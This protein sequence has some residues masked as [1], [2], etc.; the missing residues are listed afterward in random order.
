MK[1]QLGV[2]IGN[3]VVH[4]VIRR[5]WVQSPAGLRFFSKF[6]NF[7]NVFHLGEIAYV[8]TARL[9]VSRVLF[10]SLHWGG[11]GGGGKLLIKAP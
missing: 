1:K 3:A 2:E 9:C 10:R 11:G 6:L 8:R 7:L 4:V 5:S